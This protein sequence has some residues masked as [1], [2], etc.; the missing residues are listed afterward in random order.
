MSTN[1]RARIVEIIR[2][3]RVSAIIRTNSRDSAARAI[4]AAVEGGFRMVEFTLTTPSALE[5]VAEFARRDGL[6]VGAGTVLSPE[7]ARQAVQAGARFLVSPVCDPPVLAE[8]ARLDVPTIPGA[9]TP[10]EMLAAWRLGA[11]FVKLFPA[12]PGGADY[13]RAIR[14][15]LPDLPIFPTA[16]V[17]PENFTEFLDAGCVGAGFVATL[18]RP[19]DIA[20]RRFDAIRDRAAAIFTR[21]RAWTESHRAAG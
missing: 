21:L 1:Q 8:A 9:Y 4:D 16:G 20:H 17:T 3:A 10:T 2:G 11:D 5:L 6:L 14:G 12:P 7:A 19:D 13:V 15:P 18:F